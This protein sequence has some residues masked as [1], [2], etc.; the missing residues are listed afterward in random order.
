MT[1]YNQ[2]CELSDD[3][4]RARLIQ[5]ASYRPHQVFSA[6]DVCTSNR[7]RKP[8]ILRIIELLRCVWGMVVAFPSASPEISQPCR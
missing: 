7:P 6:R 2:G 3:M 1:S 8:N 5:L 4:T